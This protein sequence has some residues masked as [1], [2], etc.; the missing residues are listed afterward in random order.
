M[1]IRPTM[2]GSYLVGRDLHEYSL[3]TVRKFGDDAL[4]A[5]YE[6]SNDR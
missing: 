2:Q 3:D 5:A 1:M 6:I 4:K